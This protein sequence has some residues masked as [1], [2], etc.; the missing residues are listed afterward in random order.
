VLSLILA[1]LF[2]F[3]VGCLVIQL[4]RNFPE[5]YAQ[6]FCLLITAMTLLSAPLF[7]RTVLDQLQKIKKFEEY[8]NSQGGRRIAIYNASFFLIAN[9]I[10]VICQ[11]GTLIF[12]F[13][14][15]KQNK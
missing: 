6:Y 2:V 15:Q 14:R 5:F 10:P 12:G 13:V 11:M 9:Y 7:F 8:F 3:I 1:V 4:R